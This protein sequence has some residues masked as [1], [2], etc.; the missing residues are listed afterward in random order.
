MLH[1]AFYIKSNN[2]FVNNLLRVAF[3]LTINEVHGLNI[4]M[5]SKLS[6][7]L[8]ASCNASTNILTKDFHQQPLFALI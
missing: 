5:S 8:N 4:K 3:G 1:S 2:S 6:V 7:P